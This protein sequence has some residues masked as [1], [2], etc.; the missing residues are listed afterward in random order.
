MDMMCKASISV[1]L[2][3]EHQNYILSDSY[4]IVM[5]HFKSSS[6]GRRQD[7]G[8]EDTMQARPNRFQIHSD[9]VARHHRAGK[10]GLPKTSGS[11][12]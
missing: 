8:L 5:R 11:A 6:I 1:V 9:F 12:E 10:W 2:F 7:E 4:K 3:V